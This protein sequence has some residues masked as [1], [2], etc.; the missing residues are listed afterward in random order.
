MEIRK[1]PLYISRGEYPHCSLFPV[2]RL[3]LRKKH[4]TQRDFTKTSNTTILAPWQYVT[5]SSL[6][7]L[8]LSLGYVDKSQASMQF[9]EC[10]HMLAVPHT[11]SVVN[12]VT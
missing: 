6:A 1:F 8:H 9:T 3:Q 12:N 5:L 11:S 4:W 10:L 7:E 2:T